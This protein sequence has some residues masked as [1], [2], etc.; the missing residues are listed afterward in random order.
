MVTTYSEGPTK[1]RQRLSLLTVRASGARSVPRV[2]RL[3]GRIG[4]ANSKNW[5][6]LADYLPANLCMVFKLNSDQVSVHINAN[7]HLDRKMLFGK[8]VPWRKLSSLAAITRGGEN[9][10]SSI[11]WLSQMY[12]SRGCVAVSSTANTEYARLLYSISFWIKTCWSHNCMKH[13]KKE[14]LNVFKA[15]TV[16]WFHK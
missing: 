4:T 12:P 9:N 11:S 13:F 8:Q 2:T 1:A 3:P 16:T 6:W 15:A 14:M 5:V 10:R 7:A